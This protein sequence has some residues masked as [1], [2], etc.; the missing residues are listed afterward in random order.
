LDERR[1]RE[2][3]VDRGHEGDDDERGQDERERGD[4]RAPEPAPHVA[5]P[6]RE[7]RR[8][9]SGK[10]LRYREPFEVLL[11]CD[12]PASLDE[13]AL[14]V[15]RQRDRPTEAESAES[16]EVPREIQN[17]RLPP[18]A[19]ERSSNTTAPPDAGANT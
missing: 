17:G 18:I 12:P 7:L 1:A 5:E 8:K 6:H 3:D 2:R 11:L 10:R 16:Q 14:H 4:G 15:A 19:H 13:I 9:G